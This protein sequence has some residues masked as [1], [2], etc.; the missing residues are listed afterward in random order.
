[1]S[2]IVVCGFLLVA[3]F[4]GASGAFSVLEFVFGPKLTQHGSVRPK[5]YEV[6]PAQILVE[7]QGFR[8][9]SHDVTS[10]T[11]HILTL[12]RIPHA[13]EKIP[14]GNNQRRPVALFQHGLLAASDS[15]LFRGEDA[16]LPYILSNA[17]YDVWLSNMRGNIYSNKHVK[18]DSKRDEQYWNF[19]LEEVAKYDLPEII[20]YVLTI[21]K[22]QSLYFL[23]HSVGSTVGLM[24]CAM[25]PEYNAKIK[26]HLALAPLVYA[27]H[28]ISFTHKLVFSPMTF[29]SSV[30]RQEKIHGIFPRR[31]Y[32]SNMMEMICK[33]GMPTQPLCV[34]AI[35]L[36]VGADYPQFN[37]SS[38]PTLLNYY[39]SGTSMYLAL[40]T[41]QLYVSGKFASLDYGNSTLN[42]NQYNNT[43]PPSYNISK[44]SHPVL[45]LYG[46]GDNFV[47]ESDIKYLAKKLPNAVEIPIPYKNFNHMDFMWGIDAKNLLYERLLMLMKKYR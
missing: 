46:T 31:K 39:P 47:T 27:N 44:V 13:K 7:S 17:G 42:L 40:H 34:A 36:M 3:C 10:K 22:Q 11:G 41:I 38:I 45:L 6:T 20:D 29:L 28:P 21:A 18:Y 24:L 4:V 1:M 33:D 15:W 9:E 12:H 5:H 23:G 16:D 26:A 19:G 8:F 37:T 43:I 30:L 32:F 14:L 35:F 25:R 2:T